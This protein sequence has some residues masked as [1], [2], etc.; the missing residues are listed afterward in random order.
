MTL[1]DDLKAALVAD[2]DL[3]AIITGGVYINIS[4]LSRQTAPD[5]FDANKEIMPAILIKEGNEIPR[6]P[7]SRSV[8]TPLVFYFYQRVGF[9]VID[10]A[11]DIVFNL[12]HEERIGGGTWQILFDAKLLDDR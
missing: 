9:D 12:L 6:G 8:Q 7:Y 1:R 4:E 10:A 11:M 5:A 3:M 2:D